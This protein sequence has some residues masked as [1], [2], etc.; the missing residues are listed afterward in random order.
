M[1]REA[2][3]SAPDLVSREA[4]GG[5]AALILRVRHTVPSVDYPETESSKP[6]QEVGWQEK[7]LFFSLFVKPI[8][9]TSKDNA[10]TLFV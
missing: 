10:F 9:H 2:T 6:L 8:A 1:G 4:S 7:M 5:L 3:G